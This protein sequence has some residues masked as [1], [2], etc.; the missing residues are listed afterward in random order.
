[1]RLRSVML[2]LRHAIR[3]RYITMLLCLSS[4]MDVVVVAGFSC[5]FRVGGRVLRSIAGGLPRCRLLPPAAGS[6]RGTRRPAAS[7]AV[8]LEVV[9]PPGVGDRGLVP[10]AQLRLLG[11]GGQRGSDLV[12]GAAVEPGAGHQ[13]G[14]EAFGLAGEAGDEGDGGQVVAGPGA[15][16]LSERG[17]G[18]AGQGVGVVTAARAGSGGGH[19][20]LLPVVTAGSRGAVRTAMS[21][22][23]GTLLSG[24]AWPGPGRMRSMG[25]RRAGRSLSGQPRCRG[26]QPIIGPGPPPGSGC[27]RPGAAGGRPPGRHSV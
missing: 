18:V 27:F 25:W 21:H 8:W 16:A 12:P 10:V 9:G 23:R 14:E 2:Y 4:P 5:G 13:L 1:M 20:C 15:S 19:G 7:G 11:A 22:V 3:Q 6:E 26:C 24:Q 17:E